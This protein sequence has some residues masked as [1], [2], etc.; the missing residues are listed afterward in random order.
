MK[1]GQPVHLM[2][3]SYCL[4]FVIILSPLFAQEDPFAGFEEGKKEATLQTEEDIFGGFSEGEKTV[5]STTPAATTSSPTSEEDPFGGFLEGESASAKPQKEAVLPTTPTQTS[6]SEPKAP[7]I[8]VSFFEILEQELESYIRYFNPYE[9]YKIIKKSI[10]QKRLA[11]RKEKLA[12]EAQTSKKDQ[13]SEAKQEAKQETKQEAKQEAKQET[14]QETKQEFFIPPEIE[15]DILGIPLETPAEIMEDQKKK[16]ELSKPEISQK[17]IKEEVIT[18]PQT[19]EKQKEEI[20]D[21]FEIDED[22]PEELSISGDFVLPIITTQKD[23][24]KDVNKKPEQEE[25]KPAEISLPT[26]EIAETSEILPGI[27]P[28]PLPILPTPEPSKTKPIETS[29]IPQTPQTPQIVSEPSLEEEIIEEPERETVRV[30]MNALFEHSILNTR[31]DSFFNWDNRYN[32]FENYN[33]ILLTAQVDW[34]IYEESNLKMLLHIQDTVLYRDAIVSPEASKSSNYA[35]ADHRFENFLREALITVRYE[36]DIGITFNIG[37]QKILVGESG[38]D[39]WHPTDCF[40][41]YFVHNEIYFP[42]YASIYAANSGV[43]ERRGYRL[44]LYMASSTMNLPFGDVTFAFSP[45]INHK[46]NYSSIDENTGRLVTRREETPFYRNEFRYNI[47][48]IYYLNFTLRTEKIWKKL[49]DPVRKFLGFKVSPA[50]PEFVFSYLEYQDKWNLGLVWNAEFAEAFIAKFELNHSN[51]TSYY[52]LKEISPL[53][54][55]TPGPPPPK[56]PKIY[57]RFALGQ[58]EGDAFE[59]VFSLEYTIQKE[60]FEWLLGSSFK[61]LKLTTEYYFNSNGLSNKELDKF[62]DDMEYIDYMS[63]NV[64]AFNPQLTQQLRQYYSSL[65][66]QILAGY[67]P[68]RIGKHYLL[69]TATFTWTSDRQRDFEL[70]FVNALSMQDFSGHAGLSLQ[71]KFFSYANIKLQGEYFYGSKKSINGIMPYDWM[72]IQ[73]LELDF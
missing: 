68:D 3:I 37:K 23:E 27:S 8:T 12:K 35:L 64:T 69:N 50:D 49:N 67:R 46:G 55:V 21:G 59:S 36:G 14:K 6:A 19:P 54:I 17:P 16:E 45:E 5:K 32:L 58:Q 10:R 26:K 71:W 24:K 47:Q 57:R 52:G 28:L 61:K 20:D 34:T 44:G 63:K 48:N 33:R 43:R 13:I 62:F 66:S 29:P 39:A 22:T 72:L 31:K 11:A 18:K 65:P 70:R 25:K 51:K 7:V 56:P 53:A 60:P 9:D 15:A 38:G 40:D 1:K 2:G 41:P 30:K 42:E 4:F 73:S